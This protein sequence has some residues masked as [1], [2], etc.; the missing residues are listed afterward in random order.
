MSLKRIVVTGASG[1]VGGAIATALAD[2]GHE[3]TGY[4]RRPN[5]WSH[6]RGK[7]VQ[8]DLTRDAIPEV[9]EA[10]IV[11]H[12]AA[13]A[14]DWMPWREAFDANVRATGRIVQAGSNARLVHISSASVYD[15]F[16]PT[17][18]GSEREPLPKRYPNAYGATK[19]IA[20]R[21]VQIHPN[22]IA[23][24]PHAVYGPGDTTLLPRLLSRVKLGTL[25]LPGGGQSL[26][27]VTHI[28]TLVDAAER[29]LDSAATGSVNVGDSEPVILGDFVREALTALGRRVRILAIPVDA[30]MAIASRAEGF[31]K[32]TGVRPSITRYAV[33]QIGFER[34]LDLTR[35]HDE[36]GAQPRGPSLEFILSTNVS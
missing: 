35:L 11:V 34:T 23:L 31:A 9:R 4:G 3:V 26:H 19:S 16:T 33:T 36:L 20:E 6:P 8:R 12:S 18:Q 29:A 2:A 17:V 27:T 5:G 7:Y 22:A 21:I 10:E 14:N 13:L 32:L 24:R 25:A 28:E 1:F 15:P 30:A